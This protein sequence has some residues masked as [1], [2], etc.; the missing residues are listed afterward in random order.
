MRAE[1][2][3]ELHRNLTERA[4]DVGHEG[5]LELLREAERQAHRAREQH[6]MWSSPLRGPV[7][8]GGCETLVPKNIH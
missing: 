1:R 4:R 7:E 8:P 3:R 2:F 5:A 6:R